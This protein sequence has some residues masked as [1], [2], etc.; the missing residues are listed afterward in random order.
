MLQPGPEND[1]YKDASESASE[2]VKALL[3]GL[4][5]TADLQLK[6]QIDPK[7]KLAPA[8]REIRAAEGLLCVE[9]RFSQRLL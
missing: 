2:L 7:L 8:L 3:I 9:R 4:S 6:P 1:T 5:L